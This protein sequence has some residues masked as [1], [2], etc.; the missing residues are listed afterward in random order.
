V[1]E[2]LLPWTALV[3]AIGDQRLEG[4]RDQVLLLGVDGAS[5]DAFVM[6]STAGSLIRD[7]APP[8]APPGTLQAC[9]ALL[10]SLHLL[11]EAGW[12]VVTPEPVALAAALDA[13]PAAAL[14]TPP[15]GTVYVQ[16]PERLVWAEP[17]PGAAHEPLDGCFV[18][19]AATM[20]TVL[21]VL[22]FRPERE[23]FTTLEASAPLPAA[24]PAPR[25]DGSPPFASTLPS[26]GR[27]G[28]RS[29]AT[30]LELVALALL[31]RS[32]SGA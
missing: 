15:A 12:R 11:R 30:P 7:L 26:G 4:I 29:V 24:P 25:P 31:A 6:V 16:L 21:A 19:V 28:L 17:S 32:T 18:T 10:H 1:T 20:V 2:R 14:P 23:G 9:G 27:A 5:R 3:D 13:P 8:D 22:G